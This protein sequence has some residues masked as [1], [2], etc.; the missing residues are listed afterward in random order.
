MSRR[1]GHLNWVIRFTT[2]A[3]D[4]LLIDQQ[5][6]ERYSLTSVSS[7]YKSFLRNPVNASIAGKLSAIFFS[8]LPGN[9]SMMIMT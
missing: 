5:A 1:L 4:D 2:K 6:I 8:S 9:K 7:D 3:M